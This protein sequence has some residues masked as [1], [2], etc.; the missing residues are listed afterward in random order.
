MDQRQQGQVWEQRRMCREGL[1]MGRGGLGIA[2][3]WGTLRRE[4]NWKG[5]EQRRA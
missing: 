2:Q 3:G 1:S 4:V 5:C